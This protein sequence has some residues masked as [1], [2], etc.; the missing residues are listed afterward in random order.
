[1][2][3]VIVRSNVFRFPA[4]ERKE[5]AMGS[6]IDNMEPIRRT[7]GPFWQPCVGGCGK[8]AEALRTLEG[9]PIYCHDCAEARG[10]ARLPEPT[11]DEKRRYLGQ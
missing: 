6:R 9:S 10:I 11:W 3:D 1:M 2:L 5:T 8:R 7:P 4:I